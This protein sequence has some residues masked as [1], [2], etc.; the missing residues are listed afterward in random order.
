MSK[1]L[2]FRVWDSDDNAFR[3]FGLFNKDSFWISNHVP[4]CEERVQQFTGLKDSNGID[5]YE[6]DI[7]AASKA[8][9]YL[10]GDYEVIWNQKRGRWAYK[11]CK[12]QVGCSGN[13]KC[14]VI[15]NI[16]QSHK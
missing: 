9:S 2:K 13:L 4:K 6:G 16:F 5:I 7:C 1:D 14:R 3:Y 8:N 15:G 12:Y 10:N 11:G